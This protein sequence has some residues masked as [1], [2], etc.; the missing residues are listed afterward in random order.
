MRLDLLKFS[1]KKL[2]KLSIKD[3]KSASEILEII[4]R[5]SFL[6]SR[7]EKKKTKRNPYPAF[8]TSSM[9]IEASRKLGF[10]QLIKL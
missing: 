4:Q 3:E 2:D 1:D 5:S 7:I 9:Q 8:T 10:S 6:I